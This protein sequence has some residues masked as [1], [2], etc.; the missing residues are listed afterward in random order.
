M[1]IVLLIPKQSDGV[2]PTP[3][4]CVLNIRSITEMLLTRLCAS[5]EQYRYL[6]P[7]I[8]LIANASA[9]HDIGK[10][11]VNDQIL[12]KPGKLTPEEFDKIKAHSSIGA[13]ILEKTRYY[14]NEEIVRIAR[15]ICRWHHERY[16]GRGYPD[17]H[18]GDNIPIEAQVLS[19]GDV[20]DA[21]IHKRVYKEACSHQKAFE[22]IFSGQCGAFNP[23][24]Q[25]QRKFFSNIHIRPMFCR[26]F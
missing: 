12:N 16:D 21:L 25:C 20:Y 24:L 17:G 18:A 3:L 4:C 23:L 6:Q 13:Q 26:I 5:Q 11:S 10:I 8:M 15:D 1:S 9:L 22:L 7:Q 14:P 19:L 2:Y